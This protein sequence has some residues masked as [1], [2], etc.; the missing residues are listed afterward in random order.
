MREIELVIKISE[1]DYERL[2]VYKKAPFCSFPS[3]V[4]EAVANG[5]PPSE[6]AQATD[7]G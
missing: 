6:R 4:Y 5:T 1:E 7:R 3:R 2:K